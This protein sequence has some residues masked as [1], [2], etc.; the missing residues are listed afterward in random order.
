MLELISESPRVVIL[1]GVVPEVTS[2]GIGL[3]RAV[4]DALPAAAAAV[5]AEVGKLGVVARRRAHAR[6][7][8][9]WWAA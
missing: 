5:V 2:M 8:D 6:D 4:T 7:A 3:S 1:V 9:L